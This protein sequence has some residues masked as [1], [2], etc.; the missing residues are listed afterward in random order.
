MMIPTLM[1]I[2]ACSRVWNI[3]VH[4][5]ED[6]HVRLHQHHIPPLGT[7]T[8]R[9]NN[10]PVCSSSPPQREA[11]TPSVCRHDRRTA[12]TT[13]PSACGSI[14]WKGL[15]IGTPWCSG[16]GGVTCR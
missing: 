3:S 16:W 10:I 12:A 14:V 13:P 1:V 6:Y 4:K 5:D 8:M 7:R 11:S 2:F 15:H 9:R